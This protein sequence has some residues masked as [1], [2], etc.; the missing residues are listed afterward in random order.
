MTLTIQIMAK[1]WPGPGS[2]NAPNVAEAL[3]TMN[4][5]EERKAIAQPPSREAGRPWR[6]G[7]QVPPINDR[8][9]AGPTTRS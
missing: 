6:R 4:L 5:G 8:A 7:D 9:S 2:A 1:H 3:V